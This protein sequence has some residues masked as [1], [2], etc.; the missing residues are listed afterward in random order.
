MW[1]HK[2]NKTK[3]ISLIPKNP[4]PFPKI[5]G[6]MVEPSHP[7]EKLLY[8]HVKPL[9]AP[10]SPKNEAC[11]SRCVGCDVPKKTKNFKLLGLLGGGSYTTQILD[12][13]FGH[14][15]APKYADSGKVGICKV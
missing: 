10:I 9:Q 6:F 11:D 5:V 3:N 14:I 1:F 12:F 13:C 15:R 8:R 4:D 7:H 2:K